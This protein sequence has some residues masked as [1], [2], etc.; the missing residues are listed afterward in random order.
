MSCCGTKPI[1]GAV[2]PSALS[3]GKETVPLMIPPL[4][5]PARISIRVVF[6]APWIS[7]SVIVENTENSHTAGSEDGHHLT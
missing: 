3:K 4:P 7:V 1:L 6:P 2:W 5:L